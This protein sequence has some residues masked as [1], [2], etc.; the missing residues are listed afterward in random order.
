MGDNTKII[1]IDAQILKLRQQIDGALD[2]TSV[3]ITAKQREMDRL[4]E[5]RFALLLKMQNRTSD[6]PQDC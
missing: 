1:T 5:A 3:E 6:T 2:K 4:I